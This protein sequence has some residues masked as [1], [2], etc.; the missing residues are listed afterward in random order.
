M[1]MKLVANDIAIIEDIEEL[2]IGDYL[3][4]KPLF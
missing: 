4:V 3:G 2:R 1:L